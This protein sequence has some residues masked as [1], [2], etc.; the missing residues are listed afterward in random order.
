MKNMNTQKTSLIIFDGLG[1]SDINPE[2]NAFKQAQTPHFDRLFW[3]NN[4]SQLQASGP[5]VWI[6]DGQMWNSEVGHMTIGSGRISKQSIVEIND[7]FSQ[8]KFKDIPE[9]KESLL[10]AQQYNSTIHILWLLWEAGVHGTSLHITEILQIIP[11]NIH[12]SLHIFSDGRDSGIKKW[13]SDIENILHHIKNKKNI[14]ISSL[15]GRYFSM[16]R[17]NNWA[18]TQKSYN[19]LCN[20]GTST[21]LSPLEYIQDSYNNQ[22]YDEFIEPVRFEWWKTIEENDCVFFMNF[23]SDRARQLTQKITWENKNLFFVSMTQYYEEYTWKVF[24]KKEIITQTLAEIVSTQKYTQLHIAET[25]KFAHVTKFFSG[26]KQIIFEWQKDILVPSLKVD[27]YDMAPKMSAGSILEEYKKNASNY[28][29]SVVNFANADMLWHTGCM[30]CTVE[31]LEYIDC[32]LWEIL[33]YAHKNNIA[34]ILTADHGNCEVMGTNINP[35]TAHTTN[36]VP[37]IYIKDWKTIALKKTGGL[38]DIAPTILDIMN[39]E[40]VKEMTWES[41]LETHI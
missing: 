19:V 9:F 35:H 3:E 30:T 8:W 7:L 12:I 33:E 28:D 11:Q 10:H 31:S 4:Y 41:L 25:E 38:Q 13:F 16:D 34:L 24:V 6:L 18:R 32:I 22:K 27:S 40:K 15:S 2:E 26:G 29:F 37:C 17:D 39:I 14:T 23:R 1:I 20:N 5:A 21:L 36:L